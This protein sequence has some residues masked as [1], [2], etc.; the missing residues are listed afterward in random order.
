MTIYY[1]PK[2]C[3][4]VKSQKEFFSLQIKVDRTLKIDILTINIMKIINNLFICKKQ[5]NLLKPI[6]NQIKYSI[7]KNDY[8]PKCLINV[9]FSNN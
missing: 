3:I 9:Y 5:L 6:K 8:K 4:W 1:V 2:I 7:Q